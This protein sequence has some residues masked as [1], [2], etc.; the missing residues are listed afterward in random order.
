MGKEEIEDVE[1][2]RPQHA[3]QEE[4]ARSGNTAR[5]DQAP[6]APAEAGLPERD[7]AALTILRFR[8]VEG[9]TGSPR[10]SKQVQAVGGSHPVRVTQAEL[11]AAG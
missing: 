6:R 1:T 3:D 7:A 4:L 8:Q 10:L 9:M 2:D 11:S 5:N